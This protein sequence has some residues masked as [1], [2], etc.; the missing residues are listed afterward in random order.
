MTARVEREDG[1]AVCERCA[2]ATSPRARLRG[3]LGRR[4]L[5]AGEGL[6]LGPCASVHT[7]FLRFP[8]DV[9]FLDRDGRV[10]RVVEHLRPW[11]LTGH[12]GA[13][14]VL[15]LSA[16]ETRRRAVVPADRL[17]VLPGKL[18]TYG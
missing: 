13:R 6:L 7:C 10:L 15:E 1:G 12:R 18:A 5:P 11:R 3:L 16:G 17:S 8:I 4:W 9:V 2:V 14:S